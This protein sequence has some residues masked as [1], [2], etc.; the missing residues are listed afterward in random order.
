MLCV[1]VYFPLWTPTSQHGNKQLCAGG[2][3]IFDGLLSQ[4]DSFLPVGQFIM[5]QVDEVDL[6]IYRYQRGESSRGNKKHFVS[7]EGIFSG[8]GSSAFGYASVVLS[9]CL[10]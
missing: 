7:R 3:L 4:M 9:L 10:F 5:W 1:F 2:M 8:P 6:S